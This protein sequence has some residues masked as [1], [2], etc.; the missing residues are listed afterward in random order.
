MKTT[1]WKILLPVT[2]VAAA[3]MA[4]EYDLLPEGF[5]VRAMDGVLTEAGDSTGQSG[6]FFAFDRPLVLGNE[7]V[8]AGHKLEVLPSAA[9][10]RMA[11]EQPDNQNG[12]Y[13]L[14][15][16][17]TRYEGKNFLFVI[18]FLAINRT[19]PAAVEAATVNEPDDSFAI[20]DEIISRLKTKPVVRADQL[21]KGFELEQDSVLTHRSGRILR[22][23]DA[24]FFQ[25]DG[26]GRNI[27]PFELELLPCQPLARALRAAAE[28]LEPPRFAVSGL[29]TSYNGTNYL[30]LERATE[31]YS[32]GN[33]AG[34]Q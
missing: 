23:K 1:P 17:L 14:W 8:K 16:R 30:L 25:P 4:A 20:P 6:W 33:F 15:G 3:A 29:V 13:R 12:Y 5:P 19:E 21:Q 11:A 32:Y 24:F 34:T 28:E 26:L 2:L 7:R 9:L 22:G 10:E 27:E 18:Y 31:V